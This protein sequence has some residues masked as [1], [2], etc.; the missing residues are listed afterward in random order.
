VKSIGTDRD[1]VGRRGAAVIFDNRF[2]GFRTELIF[3]PTTSA[4]LGERETII[5]K[6]TGFREGAVIENLAFLNEA[7]TNT[8]TIPRT[9]RLH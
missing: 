5:L 8:T 6:G 1:L 2:N 4:L 3:D 7:V 9:S